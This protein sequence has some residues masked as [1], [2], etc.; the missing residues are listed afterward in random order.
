MNFETTFFLKKNWFI[1]D[2]LR[3][4]ESLLVVC[5]FDGQ[6]RVKHGIQNGV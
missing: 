6:Q 3:I 5:R 2:F 4:I 1:C